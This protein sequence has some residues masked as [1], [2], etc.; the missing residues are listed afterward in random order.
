[1]GKE[2]N[3][4][5]MPVREEFDGRARNQRSV[6]LVI[7]EP[8]ECT[9]LSLGDGELL[10]DFVEREVS[11]QIVLAERFVGFSGFPEIARYISVATQ[12]IAQEE[13]PL[14]SRVT[15]E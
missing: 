7:G 14:V 13:S 4:S 9:D 10:A 1:M 3:P 12:R 2:L 6:S 5:W 15:P 11:L 8:L